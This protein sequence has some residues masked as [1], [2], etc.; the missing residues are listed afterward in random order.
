M[1]PRK[2]ESVRSSVLRGALP[3]RAESQKRLKSSQSSRSNQSLPP[4]VPWQFGALVLHSWSGNTQR[5]FVS[6]FVLSGHCIDAPRSPERRRPQ[7]SLHPR[8]GPKVGFFF[9]RPAQQHLQSALGATDW[10]TARQPGGEE[11]GKVNV[12]QCGGKRGREALESDQQEFCAVLGQTLCLLAE[13]Y[14]DSYRK[15]PAEPLKRSALA[16]TDMYRARLW[17]LFLFVPPQQE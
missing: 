17:L 5:S 9:L 14:S 13:S 7:A 8:G 16:T 11:E 12:E 1:K 15:V 4:A 3:C 2:P 10:E 6:V